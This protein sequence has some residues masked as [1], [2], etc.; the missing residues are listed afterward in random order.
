MLC[1]YLFRVRVAQ[2]SCFV[3]DDA[4][5]YAREYF[6]RNHA[7][8]KTA[9]DACLLAAP[10]ARDVLTHKLVSPIH[11]PHATY[12]NALAVIVFFGGGYQVIR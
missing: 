7:K 11:A 3:C 6:T 5:I 2:P 4:A 12:P 8:R 1:I 9:I 10:S